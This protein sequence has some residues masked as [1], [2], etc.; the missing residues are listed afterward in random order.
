M[1]ENSETFPPV[2]DLLAVAVVAVLA[3]SE[4]EASEVAEPVEAGR[5][6]SFYR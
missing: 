6:A 3:A 5:L 2:V 4:A 1:E